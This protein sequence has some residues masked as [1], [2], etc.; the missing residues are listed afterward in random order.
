MSDKID[1]VVT[2]RILGLPI[3]L[4]LMYLLFAAT[5]TLGH[6]PVDW[7]EKS[8][9]WLSAAITDC[10]PGGPDS[11]VRAMLVEG[12]IG[13]VG[14]VLKFV[15]NIL[16]L[17]LAI[18]FLEDS[19]YMARA[20]FIVDHLMHK[21]GLHGKSFIPMLIGFGCSVPAIL[22]TRTLETRRDRL[23]TMLVVPLMSCG[24]RLPIYMLLI[25]AFFAASWQG[26]VLFSIYLIGI[27][28][29]VGCTK[30]LRATL[31][32]GE[33][34][35]FVMELPPYRMPTLQGLLIHMWQRAWMYLRKAGTV[36]LAASVILWAMTALPRKPDHDRDYQ[37]ELAQAKAARDTA[38]PA[39]RR[40]AETA[41][42]TTVVEIRQARASEDLA[43][44]VSG[45]IG[46]V[47]GPALR[48]LGFDWKI[49]TALIGAFA[50]K[51]VFVA[52][53]GIVYA[54]GHADEAPELL[55][56][57]LR[58]A[59]RP[60]QAYCIML[61]CLITAPCVATVAVMRRES[62]SWG[63]TLLQLGGLTAL[64]YVVT[65]AVYQIGRLFG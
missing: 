46:R 22:A 27:L 13:G 50:A 26:P 60:L 8:F 12:V 40:A 63:W 23:T 56:R 52:Q 55:G 59:Y 28:L 4:G 42:E 62:G 24:A 1:A 14:G 38:A 32:R 51:E 65:M 5:F 47:M 25:P 33:P 45:R 17:F 10:W 30:L 48:P 6:Y 7:L 16:L 31:F 39:A 3:F 64:A 61:F 58:E 41:Y 43:Y 9:G 11:M 34:Q 44:S 54:V 2:H 19:G 49:G 15:P 18:A 29:A 21:I 35:V 36:L 53:L 37:A 57:R 20:A